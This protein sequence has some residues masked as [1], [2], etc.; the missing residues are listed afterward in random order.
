[1]R[2]ALQAARAHLA[3]ED[4]PTVPARSGSAGDA[5][6]QELAGRY[7]SADGDAL[8]LTDGGGRLA[9]ASAAGEATLEPLGD[10]W[11]A[12]D[13][14]T[15]FAVPIPGM[16]RFALGVERDASGAVRAPTHGPQRYLA[17]GT[18]PEPTRRRPP[19]RTSSWGRT[20]AGTRG[21]R[22]SACSCARVG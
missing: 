10:L 5:P 19:A 17:D 16:D 8:V 12:H 6:R 7:S 14:T 2:F 13:E 1:M 15:G 22:A 11:E 9:M 20:G 4:L 18:P 3:G 21:R